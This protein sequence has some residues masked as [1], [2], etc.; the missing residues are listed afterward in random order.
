MAKLDSTDARR[1]RVTAICLALPE[2]V[3]SSRTG[4][5]TRYDIR[6]RTFAYYIVN[7]HNDGR[8]ALC[9]KIADA[10]R[11]ALI[12]TNPQRYYIPKYIGHHGWMCIDLDVGKIDWREIT[13]FVTNRYRMV[14]PKKLAA[15]LEHGA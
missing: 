5:H 3:A 6:G 12:A 11:A 1:A 8:V 15:R 9:C 7:E 4:Q 10:E 2:A 14:A 13:S